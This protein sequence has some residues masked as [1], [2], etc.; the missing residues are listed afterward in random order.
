MGLSLFDLASGLHGVIGIPAALH[1]K[2]NTGLG[3]HVDISMLDVSVSLLAN[4][5][6]NYLAKKQRQQRVGNNHP[7]VV[8]YQVMPAADGHFILTASNNDQFER[9]CKVAGTPELM[10]DERFNTMKA[11]VVNRAHVTPALNDIT[12]QQ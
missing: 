12:R 3:Q 4:Q 8:P 1:N 2:H 11:R 6:M 10:D 7:N 5:G 9:F